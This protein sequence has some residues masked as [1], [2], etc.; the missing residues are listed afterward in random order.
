MVGLAAGGD[1]LM[2]V[3]MKTGEKTAVLQKELRETSL[4]CALQWIS[5]RQVDSLRLQCTQ[6]VPTEA[7]AVHHEERSNFSNGGCSHPLSPSM[8]GISSQ[9]PS[10]LILSEVSHLRKLHP[11]LSFLHSTQHNLYFSCLLIF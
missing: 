3:R 1:Q 5:F 7:L 9:M 10:L 11:P 6:P 8:L 2:G 4:N